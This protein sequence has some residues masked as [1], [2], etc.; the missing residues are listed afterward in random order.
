MSASPSRAERGGLRRLLA[1]QP[2]PYAG[3]DLANA[4]RYASLVWAS[5]ALV[6]L[7]LVPFAPPTSTIGSAGW[8]VF[9]AII[10][11]ILVRIWVV[12]RSASAIDFDDLYVGSYLSLAAVALM[13]WLTGGHESPYQELFVLGAM[14]TAGTHPLRRLVPYMALMWLALAAP[15][16]YDGASSSFAAQYVTHLGVWSALIVSNF[17][18]MSRVRRKRLTLRQHGEQAERLARIDSLTGLGNRRY[19]DELL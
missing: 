10:A 11:G 8:G 3:G 16:A 14:Y 9:A 19:F 2:D 13:V 5:V 17:T 4:K 12:L 7:V 6:A 18:A 15:L 1:K